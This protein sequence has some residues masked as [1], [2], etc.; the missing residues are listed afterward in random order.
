M[1]DI[2][3]LKRKTLCRAKEVDTQQREKEKA[4]KKAYLNNMGTDLIPQG[5][6]VFFLIFSGRCFSFLAY[7]TMTPGSLCIHNSFAGLGGVVR[8]LAICSQGPAR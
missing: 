5:L 1:I 3:G 8:T 7:E 4:M 2:V 6:I